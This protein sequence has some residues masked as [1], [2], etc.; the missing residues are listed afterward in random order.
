MLPLL[1]LVRAHA[2]VDVL[3]DVA[4]VAKHLESRR[5]PLPFKPVI[6]TLARTALAMR[7]PIVIHVVNG[8]EDRLRLATAGAAVS[9]IGIENPIF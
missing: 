6:K 1:L 3:A 2:T 4:I 7:R 5:V 9:A 8:K